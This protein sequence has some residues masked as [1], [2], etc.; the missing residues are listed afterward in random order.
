MEIALF[1][2]GNFFLVLFSQFAQVLDL[3]GH[4]RSDEGGVECK[5]NIVYSPAR[6]GDEP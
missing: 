3:L 1:T 5:A 4:A 6:D 2:W